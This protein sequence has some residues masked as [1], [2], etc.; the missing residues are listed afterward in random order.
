MNNPHHDNLLLTFSNKIASLQH[1]LYPTIMNTVTVKPKF[2]VT[3]PAELRKSINIK[4]G[5]I[6]EAVRVEDGIII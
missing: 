2:Q 6:M 1:N 5:D 3:I 4:E